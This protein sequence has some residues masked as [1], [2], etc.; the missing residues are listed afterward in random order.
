MR[1]TRIGALVAL[2]IVIL[3]MTIFSLGEQQHFWER[4]VQYEIHFARTN[5]L[6][7]GAPVSLTGVTVGSVADMRFPIDPAARFIQVVVN[8]SGDVASRIRENTTATIRTYG[9]LGDR[10]IELTAGTPD[11]APVPP[12]GLITSI[13]PVDYEAVLGQSGDIVDNV[14]QVTASL[15]AVLQAVEQGEGLL[16]AALRNREIGEATLHDLQRTMA[17]VQGTTASLAEILRRVERG[18]GLVGR[19][20]RSTKEDQELVQRLGRTAKS[21]DEFSARLNGDDG[22]VARLVHDDAYATRVLGNLD[23]MLADLASAAAKLDHGQGTL[24]RLLNDPGLY[25]DAEGLLGRARDSW[26]L[27]FFGLTASGRATSDRAESMSAAA[28]EPSLGADRSP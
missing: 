8:V 20:T 12:G 23:R 19:L 10:Y 2:A 9:L 27:R 24:G 3:M 1:T 4:K 5:G 16:G 11:A 14:V 6:Q 26:F 13:D 28:A 25:E 18:E 22:V 21:L 17:N 7:K 15:K